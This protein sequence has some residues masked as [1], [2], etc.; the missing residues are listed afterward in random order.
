MIET[1]KRLFEI[2]PHS[3][4]WKFAALFVLMMIGTVLELIG[5]GMIPLFVAS[6]AT[7]QTI[8]N[9]QWLGPVAAFIGIKTAKDLLFYGGIGLIIIFVLKGAYAVWY[10]YMKARFINNR[11]VMISSRLFEA[12]LSAP[13]TLHIERNTAELIRNVNMESRFVSTKILM[14]FVTILKDGVTALGIFCLLMVFKPLITVFAFLLIGGGGALFLRIMRKRL[15]RYGKIG[16]KERKRMIQGVEEGLGGYK[17][18]TVMNRQQFFIDRF[19]KYVRNLNNARIKKVVISSFIRPGI[20]FLSVVGIVLIAF[21]MIW[22]GQTLASIIPILALFGT[23]TVR[24][25]PA[26]QKIVTNINQ[27]QYF[28][29]ALEPVYRDM[30][31]LQKNYREIANNRRNKSKLPFFQQIELKDIWFRYPNS[32]Q[33]VLEN[34]NLSIHKKTAVG[35]VGPTGAGKSTVVDVILGLLEHQSGQVLV[36]GTDISEN[37][38]AWQNNVGYIPQFIYLSDDTIRNNIAF[39]IPDNLISDAKVEAALQAAQLGEFVNN[40]PAELDT[41]VGENGIKL[42]GGQRQRVGIARAL[43]DNPD[44]LIMDEGTASLDKLTEKHVIKAIEA[45]KGERTIIMI[46][47][48]LS[49]VQN[50]DKLFMMKQGRIIDSGTYNELLE[51]NGEFREMS[52]G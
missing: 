10:K 42:S 44:V 25:M 52:L 4:R 6:L 7:P 5:I 32:E 27:I 1:L 35:F 46:A 2:F 13:Y 16:S 38:R 31:D 24:L 51:H 8:L 18:V 39:G 14:P 22:Q 29:H 12:Y 21:F 17:D 36:D 37:K 50:C 47:H 43:Y 3:D 23:A 41:K 40:L 26:I 48:N 28:D 33:Y 19:K 11:Y 9:N 15:R 34:V 49:T 30:K 45:L 20:E